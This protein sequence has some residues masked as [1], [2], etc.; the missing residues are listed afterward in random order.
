M[1]KHNGMRP[2]DIVV[3][4]KILAKKE[5]PWTMKEIASELFISAS[6]VSE[7]MA[8]NVY[9]GLLKGN[10]KEIM[11][12]D[13]LNFLKSGLKFVFPVKPSA[14]GRGMA[15]A[16]SAKPL[17]SKIQSSEKI[18]WSY[19]TGKEKGMVIEPLILSIPKACETDPY[20]YELMSLVEAF[21]IGKIREV[22][23]AYEEL[24]SR[25]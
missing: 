24:S 13:F 17:S 9:A 1:R 12:T 23:L 2:Q 8:R 20:F 6:E 14:I 22:Q 7:A 4:V 5:T 21:R 3:L 10:K 19:A 18:V 25:I 16:Y 15:T 11:K